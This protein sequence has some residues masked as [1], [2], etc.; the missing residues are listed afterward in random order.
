[1]CVFECVYVCV[2][3]VGPSVYLSVKMQLPVYLN[4]LLESE[5]PLSVCHVCPAG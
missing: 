5:V 4:G 1:M 2:G 3:V